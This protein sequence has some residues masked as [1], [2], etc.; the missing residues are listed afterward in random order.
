[1]NYKAIEVELSDFKKDEVGVFIN[2]LKSLESEYWFKKVTEQELVAAYKKVAIDG[3]YV[4]GTTITLQM[5][6]DKLLISYGYQAYKNKL[7]MAYPESMIDI[8]NVYEGDEFTW[9]KRD[10]KIHYNHRPANALNEGGKI[11]GAYCI[12]KNQRGEF[13]EVLNQTELGKM[14]AV[15]KTLTIWNKWES[16]MVKKSVIKRACKTHFYDKFVNVEAADNA[17]YELEDV[18]VP[19][20]LKF[21]IEC[22]A[23]TEEL[24]QIYKDR[25]KEV[26]ELKIEHVFMRLL[27]DRK[28]EIGVTA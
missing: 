25:I 28:D 24:N 10:G 26:K 21:D 27:K 5:R 6:G 23:T 8:Q 18:D 1:M 15:A 2:Y 22:A 19:V 7:L 9:S 4:D 13:I 12:I 17:N 16:E 14:K 3:L 11:A 20:D